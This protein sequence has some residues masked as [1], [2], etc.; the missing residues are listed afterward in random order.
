MS[1]RDGTVGVLHGDPDV[2]EQFRRWL[3]DRYDVWTAAPPD[4]VT[5]APATTDVLVVDWSLSP[6]TRQAIVEAA[7][8]AD[9]PAILAVIEGVP[10]EDPNTNGAD[11]YLANPERG[12]VL[13]A[14]VRVLVL[15]QEY[16]RTL[17]RLSAQFACQEPDSPPEP[18]ASPENGPRETDDD[19]PEG[20]LDH[21]SPEVRELARRADRLLSELADEVSYTYL[22]DRLF[23]E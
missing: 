7:E 19:P 3:D 23:R 1:D 20:E 21:E 5:V 15:R 13:D 10:D 11:D 12:R 4:G 17:D 16:W 14:A 6:R 9:S 22:F 2:A 8:G 18:G